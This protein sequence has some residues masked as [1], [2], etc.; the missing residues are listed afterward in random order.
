MA[1]LLAGVDV[2]TIKLIGRWRSDAMFRYLHAQAMPLV[3][4]LAGQMF[5]HGEYSLLPGGLT[6]S[7]AQ[8]ILAAANFPLDDCQPRFG[9]EPDDDDDDETVEDPSPLNTFAATLIS[10]PC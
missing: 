5:N 3:G 4:P 7:Q 8:S 1:L 9:P 2:D 6:P 10:T